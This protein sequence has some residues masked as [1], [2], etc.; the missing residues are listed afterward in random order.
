MLKDCIKPVALAL[1]CEAILTN[2]PTA[3]IDKDVPFTVI[4]L[5]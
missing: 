1:T 3:V 2:P 5:Q 4:E